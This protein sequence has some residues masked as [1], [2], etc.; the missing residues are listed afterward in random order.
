MFHK[1]LE[2]IRDKVKKMRARLYTEN[3]KTFMRGIK[4]DLS[5]WRGMEKGGLPIPFKALIS[6]HV[7]GLTYSQLLGHLFCLN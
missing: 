6:V 1:H 3:G 7:C 5:T 2:M 4:E